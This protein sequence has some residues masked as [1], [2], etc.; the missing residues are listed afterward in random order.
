[1]FLDLLL[2]SVNALMSNVD[3]ILHCDLRAVRAH[4]VYC[5]S[6]LGQRIVAHCMAC[7]LL[8]YQSNDFILMYVAVFASVCLFRGIEFTRP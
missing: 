8:A 4:A 5:L 3:D 6:L 7:L 2:S 1:M